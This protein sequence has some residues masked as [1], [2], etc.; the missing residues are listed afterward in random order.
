[1]RRRVTLVWNKMG[2]GFLIFIHSA[3][4]TRMTARH[5][6]E[7]KFYNMSQTW[8]STNNFPFGHLNRIAVP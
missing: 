6:E 5:S 1:M 8:T 2:I 3:L 4:K 7:E